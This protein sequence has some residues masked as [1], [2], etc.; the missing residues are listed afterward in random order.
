MLHVAHYL[1]R[2]MAHFFATS[3]KRMRKKSSRPIREILRNQKQ[4]VK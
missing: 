2:M 1:K 3:A 4:N